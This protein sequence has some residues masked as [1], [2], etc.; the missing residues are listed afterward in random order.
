MKK[1]AVILSLFLLNISTVMAFG[2]SPFG[3]ST[4]NINAATAAANNAAMAAN[5]YPITASL[6]GSTLGVKY[7]QNSPHMN[8]VILY[9]NTPPIQIAIEA[10]CKKFNFK[11][12]RSNSAASLSESVELSSGVCMV[13]V[14]TNVLSQTTLPGDFAVELNQFCSQV[15]E[16]ATHLYD[17]Q[18][19]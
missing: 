11:N 14:N 17:Y 12:M 7:K 6:I 16:N 10:A 13:W 15:P 19:N 5:R 4:T 9:G 18:C 3:P 2:G 8:D 1:Y